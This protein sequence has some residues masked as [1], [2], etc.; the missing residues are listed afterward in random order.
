M[1]AFC[2]DNQSDPKKVQ[3]ALKD[4]K[5]TVLLGKLA[6]KAL[7]ALKKGEPHDR[8]VL[9]VRTRRVVGEYDPVYRRGSTREY[10]TSIHR[11]PAL[12]PVSRQDLPD[13]DKL[14]VE[15][16]S[17]KKVEV[18]GWILSEAPV[19]L[20]GTGLLMKVDESTMRY[21]G[22]VARVVFNSET[23]LALLGTLRIKKK[24]L[25]FIPNTVYSNGCNNIIELSAGRE[26]T[27]LAEIVAGVL[28]N[29]NSTATSQRRSLIPQKMIDLQRNAAAWIIEDGIVHRMIQEMKNQVEVLKV[30]ET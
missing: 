26:W 24:G 10:E 27:R 13:L 7:K 12:R 29:F 28:V 2:V 4:L 11:F 30:M 14:S 8:P 19:Y 5:R 1:F 25:S 6:E 15:F 9:T 18:A 17:F 21:T 3:R 20:S 16:G 22:K 23:D